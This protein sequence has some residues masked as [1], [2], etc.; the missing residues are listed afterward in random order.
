MY[1]VG[2]ARL[3]QHAQQVDAL[4]VFPVP[5]GDTGTNMN[6]T[7]TSGVA[8]LEKSAEQTAEKVASVFSRGLL[9]GARGNSGVIL[10]QLFRGFAKGLTG[11]GEADARQVADAFQQ[12]V[13][14][15]YKAVMKPVEGTILTVARE[16]AAAARKAARG[17][18]EEVIE[19]LVVAAQ[20]AL[21]HTPNQLPVLKEVGVVDS[22]GQGLVY[23]Y[24]GFLQAL[25]EDV[26]FEKRVVDSKPQAP[27]AAIF[28]EAHE[29]MH[30]VINPADIVY[31]Y[32]TEFMVH[33]RE[34]NGFRMEAFRERISQY[35]D[36]LL[37][38][39][40]DDLIKVHIHAEEPGDVLSFAHKYGTLDRIKIE[41]MRLQHEAVLRRQ[42]AKQQ[43]VSPVPA[44]PIEAASAVVE[45]VVPPL[46]FVVEPQKASERY[47]MIAVASGAGITEIFRSL[48]V[49]TIIEGGQT[50][51]PS[52]EQFVQAIEASGAS[53]VIILPNNKNIIMAAKQA[54]ELVDIPVAVIP[55]VSVPQGMSAMLAFAPEAELVHN[56]ASM[57]E[58]VGLVKTGL[59]TY[60]VRD[61][62]LNEIEI[63][64]GDFIG[65]QDGEIV[66][67]G[68]DMYTVATDLVACMVE[69]DDELITVLYG[70]DS[71][72]AKLDE[73]E[74]RIR[75]TYSSYEV[76][77]H[78]GGQPLYAFIIAVE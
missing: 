11:L 27:T 5:D 3:T 8:E 39:A 67:A 65:I 4:N 60:A 35:G 43:T 26:S 48:G 69:K 74:K 32:C 2:A 73:W 54:A 16:A 49:G 56:E 61:T 50:M 36:S 46:D 18:V 76:E 28:G 20:R 62:K 72:E 19:A 52:T 40:D 78:E 21:D 66:A 10:S 33:L 59:V 22:G 1:K 68:S 30:H 57:T 25:N 38:V 47:G 14:M 12:G 51:N 24:E 53:N 31:G 44:V 13:D 77:V 6:L 29:E 41:N 55:A 17:T 58:A 23:I 34:T 63:K 9:M 64:E 7:F 37:V 45:D 42:E 75:E 71:T 70:A 15:A